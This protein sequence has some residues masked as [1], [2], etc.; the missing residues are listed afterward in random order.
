MIKAIIFDHDGTLV[1]SEREHFKV[2]Q[3][4]LREYGVS[5]EE[6]EYIERYTGV[7]TLATAEGIVNTYSLPVSGEALYQAK[8]KR[9][10][11]HFQDTVPELMPG[12]TECL[13]FA[14]EHFQ[15]AVAT[16]A[17]S[18]ELVHSL[19]SNQLVSY[20]SAT[21]TG[22]EVENAKPAPD[23]YLLA[24]ERLGLRP[25]DCIAIEDSRSGLMSAKAAGL[26]CIFIPNDYTKGH[27]SRE[28]DFVVNSLLDVKQLL[29]NSI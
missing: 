2:W 20:F 18:S 9:V 4:L 26:S 23:V 13:A 19:Q 8:L 21:A 3:S 16:G 24:I 12:V 28:A 29:S 5:F 17:T 27:D 1:N 25:E 7:P 10:E 11:E 14:S 15:L 22:S 6:H